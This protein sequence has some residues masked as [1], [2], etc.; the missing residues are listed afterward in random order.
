MF[1]GDSADYQHIFL[2]DLPLVDV[3]APIEFIQGA[4]EHA[5]NLPLMND[6][7]RQAVG[8]CY[9]QQGQDAAIALGEQLVSGETREQRIEQWRDFCRQ[10]PQGYLYCLRGGLRSHITQRWLREAG[11]DYPLV[12]GG[13]K[14]LRNCLMDINRQAATMPLRVI[15]GNTG[16]GK[17]LLVRDLPFGLDLEGAARHRG[18]SFG[19]TLVSQSTQIN[20]EHRIAVTLLKKHHA[21]INRWVIED[22]GKTIGS[23][24]VPLEMY[25]SMQ[26]AGMAVIEDPFEVRLARLQQEYIDNMSAEFERVYGIESGW[27]KFCEYLRHGMFAIRK[28]LGMERYQVLLNE[29]DMALLAQKQ[30]KGSTQHESWLVPLLIE[31]YDPMYAYQLSKKADR[32]IFRG[33]FAEV[34]DFLLNDIH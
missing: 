33:N 31:Y 25:E 29:L 2:N 9:K 4:F 22:E 21:G 1:R 34:R 15:G 13:Y 16:C 30:G 27:E 11:V 19:R 20:F 7:E 8:I 12:K 32:I 23:N 18:S 26:Q 6:D 5:T 14:A 17:T 24:H 10:H 28:R 3:R